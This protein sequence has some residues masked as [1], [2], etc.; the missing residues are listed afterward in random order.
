[1]VEHVNL[2]S[3]K[4]LAALERC[5][6]E[7]N[8]NREPQ[9]YVGEYGVLETL[10]Q[11]AF[12]VVHKVMRRGAKELVYALKEIQTKNTT[13]FGSTADK[14]TQ[15]M[16]SILNEVRTRL[17]LVNFTCLYV[18]VYVCVCVRVCVCV[19]VCVCVRVRVC[20]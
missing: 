17:L 16:R 1:M 10:G 3:E 15:S 7:T 11:G 4:E 9:R 13:V 20:V 12:G 5:V 6:S 8:V 14:Q 18:C 19:C 2:L